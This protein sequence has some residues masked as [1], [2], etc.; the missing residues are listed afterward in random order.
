MGDDWD[1]EFYGPEDNDEDCDFA[2]PGGTSALRR[3]TPENPRNKPCPTCHWPD[4]LTARDVSLG[5]QCNDCANAMERGG[6]I[7]YFEG[8]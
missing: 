5:Y 3:E 4:R 1:D 6:G 8:E 7:N 2:D